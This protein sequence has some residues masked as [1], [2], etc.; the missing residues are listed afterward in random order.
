M[1]R[2]PVPSDTTDER[3]RSRGGLVAGLIVVALVAGG[4]WWWFAGREP[5]ATAPAAGAPGAPA[6]S[7][8]DKAG[9]VGKKGFDPSNRPQPVAVATV[10]QQNVN[11]YL[12]ALGTVTPLRT[13]TVRPRVEGQLLRVNFTEGQMVKEGDLL[14]EVDPRPF[15]VQLMQ[16]EGQMAKD[17]ALLANAKVD[18]ERYRTLFAQD[19]IA[20]QQL[21]TQASL[22]RQYE[23][24][25]QL[26]QAQIDSAKLQLT[27]T[28]ITAPISGRIGLRQVDPGNVIRASDA[29]GL[30]VIAQLQPIAA[31]FPIPQDNLQAVMKRTRGAQR[32]PVEAWDREQKTK[33]A[34]GT[35]ITVDNQIDPQTGT[36]R[37]KAEFPNR[38][39]ELFPNQFVNVR[40]LVDTLKDA[41]VVPQAAVQ[42]GSRGVFVFV[43]GADGTVSL[44]NVEVGP[45]EGQVVAVTGGIA[46]GDR[47]VI[48]GTDRLR[49]GAR[50]E[51]AGEGRPRGGPPGAGAPG[52]PGASG[53][54]GASGAPAA[55]GAAGAGAAGA[56]PSGAPATGAP[57]APGTPAVTPTP[58]A[59]KGGERSGAAAPTSAST[60]GA[61]SAA[62]ASAA[63]VADGR[64]P[65]AE[66]G[67]FDPARAE[68]W[69]NMSEAEKSEMRE[70]RRREREQQGASQ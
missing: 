6:A 18:L 37:L 49:D 40:M 63:P 65:R 16:A 15:Q 51:V 59:P 35:L 41:L 5:A 11:V 46:A 1:K 10:R 30:V 2:D 12:N 60:P 68:R 47:V 13:V 57:G 70:R 22:V 50:V 21:D 69:K 31:I 4:A 43:V 28:R 53:A 27:Y 38:D 14:A 66:A 34:S 55:S 52:A 25:I 62:P 58:G 20:R 26:D 33:L 29:N 24:A 8:A 9:R 56:R 48:E 39:M 54:S 7:G 44:R 42:R 67:G 32:I 23:G 64:G 61:A 36:V 17:Q 3:P 45:T 19:S